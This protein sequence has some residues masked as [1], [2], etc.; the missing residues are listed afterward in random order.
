MFD[1]ELSPGQLRNL[2]KAFSEGQGGRQ[3]SCKET[4]HGWGAQVLTPTHHRHLA[5]SNRNAT[6]SCVCACAD[7][8]VRAV[9]VC[10]SIR[11]GSKK[12]TWKQ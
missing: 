4:S 7:F 2:E 10:G 11:R 6:C 5:H 1:D 9:D 12:E 3:V 8:Q